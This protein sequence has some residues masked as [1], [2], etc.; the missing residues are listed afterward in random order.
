[1]CHIAPKLS[2]PRQDR[3]HTYRGWP[4]NRL[5]I[6][7]ENLTLGRVPALVLGP[8]C[9]DITSIFAAMSGER[10]VQHCQQ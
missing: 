6:N 4:T 9:S 2:Y 10:S 3:Q 7:S 1:M 8:P 5:R